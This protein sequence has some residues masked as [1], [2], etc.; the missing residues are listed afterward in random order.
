MDK[1]EA[2]LQT[3]SESYPDLPIR[4]AH[5]HNKDGQYNDILIINDE[6]IFRF[7]RYAEGVK[8]IE[9]EVCILNRIQGYT[10][11][12]IPN[13]I[14]ASKDEQRLGKV[15]MGYRMLP[16]E[17]LWRDIL[18]SIE[19]D[20]VLQRLADQLAGFLKELHSIPIESV[21]TELP[22]HDSVADTSKL[23]RRYAL[24]SFV[25]CALM[26]AIGLK[27]ILRSI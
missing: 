12:P 8:S 15:F 14:Y 24:I 22:V 26:R 21:G 27:I 3:L 9:N 19:D 23:M 17:P 16:G 7:P 1:Q 20:E 11:L 25:L 4:N 5:L 10:T 18:Q 2:Y 6:I 13:P